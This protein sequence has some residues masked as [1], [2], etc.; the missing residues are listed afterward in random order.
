M[1]IPKNQESLDPPKKRGLTLQ[2]A[3]FW[4]LQSTSDL[5]SHDS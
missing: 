4:D 5:R 2:F 1:F 3:G